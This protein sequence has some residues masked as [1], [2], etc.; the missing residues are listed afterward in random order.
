MDILGFYRPVHRC[1]LC[2]NDTLSR[3]CSECYS[4]LPKI[5]NPCPVCAIPDIPQQALCGQCL[6]NPPDFDQVRCAF[7]YQMPLDQLIRGFKHRRQLTTGRAL[8]ELL[9]VDLEGRYAS[10]EL[11]DKITAAPLFWRKQWSR[12]FNQSLC[13]SHYLS[14]RLGIEHFNGLQR[15]RANSEQKT[16]NRKQRLENL[17]YCFAVKKPLNGEH[18]AVVDDVVT[19]GATA[20][21]IAKVLKEAGANKV[22]IWAVARTPRVG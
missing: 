7:L 11:P 10:E 18:I 17:K 9:L 21:T 3:I 14:R 4:L 1:I 8:A 12:G 13:L 20:N 15:I 6:S 16:L 2:H 19:T 22:T 5:N